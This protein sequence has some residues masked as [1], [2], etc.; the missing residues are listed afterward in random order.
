MGFIAKSGSFFTAMFI[1][2]D[3]EEEDETQPIY[4]RLYVC[5]DNNQDSVPTYY[6]ST[7]QDRPPKIDVKHSALRTLRYPQYKV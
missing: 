7:M 3:F 4:D 2:V 5:P 1:V 6:H